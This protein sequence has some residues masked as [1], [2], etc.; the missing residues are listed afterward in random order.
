MSAPGAS[1]ATLARKSCGESTRRASS[2]PFVSV[3]PQVDRRQRDGKLP[4]IAQG[5]RESERVVVAEPAERGA[6]DDDVVDPLGRVD[7][8]AGKIAPR[9]QQRSNARPA[10]RNGVAEVMRGL[11]RE[12][13]AEKHQRHRE[14][15]PNARLLPA[16]TPLRLAQEVERAVIGLRRRGGFRLLRLPARRCRVPAALPRRR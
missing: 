8:A 2:W 10:C 3:R 12:Q 4:A 11:Q 9:Q 6:V 7:A 16:R 5:H 15:K 13:Q 1:V 14:R